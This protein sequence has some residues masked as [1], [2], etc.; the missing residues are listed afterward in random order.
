MGAFEQLYRTYGARLKS[1]AYHIAGSRQDAEDAVQETFLKAYRGIDGFAGGSSIGTWLCRICINACYDLVRKAAT[2]RSTRRAR[3]AGSSGAAVRPARATP[4]GARAHRSA[5]PYG[6]SVVRVEGMKHSGNCGHPADP[7]GDVEG[8]AVRSQTGI[9]ASADGDTAMI[10][11]CGDLERALRTPELM[12]DARAHCRE[13]PGVPLSNL[14]V[15]GDLAPRTAIA[16]GVGKRPVMA[17]HPRQP[18]NSTAAEKEAA[19]LAL[20]PGS[21]RLRG[22]RHRSPV[23]AARARPSAANCSPTRRSRRYSRL[24]PPTR[25]PSRIWQPRPGPNSNGLR[26]RSLLRTA[27]SL[28]CSIPLS[29]G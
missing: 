29:T 19:T 17:A 16:P 6:F 7:G 27:K 2:R 1:V 4:A 22:A 11:Q 14:F 3:T 10:F 15:D 26:R 18:G 5:A 12:P 24:K 8:L 21:R 23:S 28:P 9:A 20:G 13:L 25:A